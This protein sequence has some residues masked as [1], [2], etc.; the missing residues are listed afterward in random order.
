M[1]KHFELSISGTKHDFGAAAVA[2]ISGCPQCL[3][4]AITLLMV[5]D[6]DFRKL[7]NECGREANIIRENNRKGK[8][9]PNPQMN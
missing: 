2:N 1:D 7:I 8:Q 6:D 3:K 9:G 4:R 5:H